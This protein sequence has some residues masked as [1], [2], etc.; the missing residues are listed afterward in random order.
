MHAGPEA[1]RV[2]GRV[3]DGLW[4]TTLASFAH[5]RLTGQLVVTAGDG[6]Q[7]RVAFHEGIVVAA[8]SPYVADAVVR[9][10][11]TERLVSSSQVAAI[12]TRV[13]AFPGRDE[14]DLVSEAARLPVEHAVRL[15]RRVITQRA[16]R[17]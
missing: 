4:G 13:R 8:A 9:I 7:V 3:E 14:V 2:T 1:A 16:A 11:L 12:A 15:R 17:T 5:Q 6:K 10:A